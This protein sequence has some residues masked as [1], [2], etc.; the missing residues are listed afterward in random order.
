MTMNVEAQ[1]KRRRPSS[2]RKDAWNLPN[3]LTMGR[4]AI[5]PLV[6]WLLDRGEPR[7]C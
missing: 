7:A 2:L 6:L 3:L 4:V 1:S 5:I